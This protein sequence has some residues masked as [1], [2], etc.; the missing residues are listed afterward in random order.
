MWKYRRRSPIVPRIRA[1]VF[2][3]T[4]PNRRVPARARAWRNARGA[5][6]SFMVGRSGATS[7]GC[8]ICHGPHVSIAAAGEIFSMTKRTTGE[9]RWA[10][11]IALLTR[12]RSTMRA[13]GSRGEVPGEAEDSTD[14]RLRASSSRARFPAAVFT[15]PRDSVCINSCTNH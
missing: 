2:R 10:V 15:L 13:D 5:L 3:A 9:G 8:A 6:T 4:C 1:H 11:Q 12:T 7:I 14:R